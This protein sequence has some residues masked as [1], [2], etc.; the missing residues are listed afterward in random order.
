MQTRCYVLRF[1]IVLWAL[2]GLSPYLSGIAPDGA[3]DGMGVRDLCEGPTSQDPDRFESVYSHMLVF[4]K[5]GQYDKVILGCR[6]IISGNIE[7]IK[8]YE[9]LLQAVNKQVAHSSSFQAYEQI[10]RYF[11]NILTDNPHTPYAHYGLGLSYKYGR[12]YSEAVKHFKKSIDLGANFWKVYEELI[13]Y[14]RHQEELES[15]IRLWEQRC[16]AQPDNPYLYQGLAYLHFWLDDYD[17][18]LKHYNRALRLHEQKGDQRAVANCLYYLA[19]LQMYLNLYE[20]ASETIHRSIGLSRSVGDNYQLVKSLELLSFIHFERSDYSKAH[21]LCDRAYSM[22]RDLSN[23]KLEALC[24]RTLGVL[25]TEFGNL[26][27]AREYLERSSE[28]YRKLGETQKYNVSLYWRTVLYNGMGDYSSALAAAKQGLRISQ[29]LGFK[30][31]QAFLLSEIGDIYYS[32]G[33]YERALDYNKRALVISE[34][35]IGKWSREKCMNA[36]GYVYLERGKYAEALD[37]FNQALSYIRR[38]GHTREEAECLYNIGLAHFYNGDIEEAKK[39]FLASLKRAD[40][41]GEKAIEGKNYNRLGKLH[42]EIDDCEH[43]NL[44]YSRALA[45]G[46]GIG[47]P[48]IIWE[49]HSGL[50]EVHAQQKKLEQAVSSY[51]KSIEV[52]EGLRSQF[53]VS[54]YRS[55]F[56]QSKVRIYEQLINLLYELHVAN[57]SLGFDRECFFFAE[58]AKARAFLD[59]LQRAGI[60]FSSLFEEQKDDIETRSKKISHILTKLSH[61]ELGSEEKER[62][63][64]ELEKI[65]DELQNLIE[66]VKK[67]HP[68]YAKTVGLEPLDLTTIQDKLLDDNTGLVA[69]FVGE[70]NIFIFFCTRHGISIH[71]VP[72]GRSQSTRNIVRNYLKLLSSRKFTCKDCETAGRNLCE[73]LI[74]MQSNGFSSS[75]KQLIIIPDGELHYLPFETLV[76]QGLGYPETDRPFYLME[77]FRISYAPSASTLFSII[78][79]DR[80]HALNRDLLVVG[81]PVYTNGSMLTRDP[82]KSDDIV[83]EYYLKE[84]FNVFPLKYAAKEAES[85]CRQLKKDAALLISQ[86]DANEETVKSLPLHDFRIIHFA[87]HSLLDEKNA[88][89]SAL[90]L[91]L[92]DDPREDG[93]FQAREIYGVRLNADLVVLSACQTAKGKI[94]KGEGIQGLARAFFYAGTKSVLASLWKIDDRSTAQFMKLFYEFLTEGKTKQEALAL[95]KIRMLDTEYRKPYYWASFVLIGESDSPVTLQKSSWLDRL[96]N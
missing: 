96:F 41:S 40:Q 21:E 85:I 84:K 55:G 49:A 12:K 4:Y 22:A 6:D 90:V 53:V 26:T 89:R 25:H 93:F 64:Q 87:T 62:L 75:I 73:R 3:A 67:E 77:Q 38:I 24:L 30:T 36:I 2:F 29:Q 57:P 66:V 88:N 45:I 1:F 68:D 69:Y 37:Y 60:D 10:I 91:N 72:P 81:D 32:L 7:F 48:N 39:L 78:N 94:E 11:Q 95:A 58:K 46:K 59:D 5:L 31:G 79:N 35:Y 92:D 28:F 61:A 51:K 86:E 19:Y 74:R 63:R 33:N 65:E 42:C 76:C 70:R 80:K 23:E 18:S 52:I 82:F 47:H 71:R 9:L 20:E 34:K 54:E 50:G 13:P 27:R 56:F 14:L 43:A 44:Y 15:L 83:Y 8:A 17:P 16:M